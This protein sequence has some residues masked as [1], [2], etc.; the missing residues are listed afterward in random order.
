[1]Q[2]TDSNRP[3]FLGGPRAIT[4]EHDEV[5][6][7]PDLTRDDAIAVLQVMCDGDISNHRVIRQLESAYAERFGRKHVLAHNSGSC[8]LLSACYAID[9]QP[10]DQV[11]VSTAAPVASVLPLLWVGAVPVFC[12]IE[13]ER[14]GI[15]PTDAARRITPKTRAIMV[16]HLWGMPG[17]MTALVNLARKFKLKIIEDASHAQGA[18]WKEKACGS[19]GDVAVIHLNKES[20]APTGQGGIFMCDKTS[21]YERAVCLGE[22]TR[23]NALEPSS[24]RKAAAGFGLNTRMPPISAAIGLNQIEHL[25]QHNAARNRNLG[26]LS[27]HLEKLGFHTFMSNRRNHRVYHEFRIRYDERKHKLPRKKLVQALNMEGCEVTAP[28]HP[29]L[30]EQ[31]IFR[32]NNPDSESILKT[33][34][35]RADR[36]RSL[37]ATERLM[38]SLIKLPTFPGQDNGII[39][40]Y[41]HA[42]EKVMHH[43]DE[44][45]GRPSVG[46]Q[47]QT[48]HVPRLRV[49][50]TT[51]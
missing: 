37:K 45:A 48:D 39:D 41:I 51:A 28:E 40:Q 19:I 18:A 21:C 50:E 47:A 9:L 20:L 4:K 35:S 31:P 17:R 11:L 46:G 29:L 23:I 27:Q 33:T 14:L 2:R 3:A 49:V 8:A 44:I 43:A 6:R 36:P 1:M 42:F 10:E 34:S 24:R 26:Y 38:H 5:V 13:P 25:E 16:S 15:D 7:W 12:N 30:H 22:P 32:E